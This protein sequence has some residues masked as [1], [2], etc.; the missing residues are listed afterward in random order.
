MSL[1]DWF[2]SAA[3]I[4]RP[5][6]DGDV[7]TRKQYAFLEWLRNNEM[8]FL[9]LEWRDGESGARV[10]NLAVQNAIDYLVDPQALDAE[11][12]AVKEEG[13]MLPYPDSTVGPRQFL[14]RLRLEM[15]LRVFLGQRGG[16][17]RSMKCH[18]ILRHCGVQRRNETFCR[19][20]ERA[21]AF[22]HVGLRRAWDDAV[23]ISVAKFRLFESLILIRL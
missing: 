14:K 6:V 13:G 2:Y 12:N 21:A 22:Y 7:P 4:A 20:F 3:D 16:R 23:F 11:R 19:E 15:A 8:P 17:R 5:L 10:M 1:P 9:P 18:T